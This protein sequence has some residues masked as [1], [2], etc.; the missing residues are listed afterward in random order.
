MFGR[1]RAG[2]SAGGDDSLWSKRKETSRLLQTPGIY[3]PYCLRLLIMPHFLKI[4]VDHDCAPVRGQVFHT[5][6]IRL[7][8]IQVILGLSTK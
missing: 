2:R 1:A 3:T 6:V 5:K 7:A 4:L 8:L